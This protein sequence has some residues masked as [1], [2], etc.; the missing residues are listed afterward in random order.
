MFE[1]ALLET[2]RN[3]LVESPISKLVTEDNI[4]IT[5]KDEPP[6]TVGQHFI[7]IMPSQRENVSETG[8]TNSSKNYVVDRIGIDVVCGARTRLAPTDRLG[9]YMTKEHLNLSVLK[10]LV[11]TYVS[12]LNSSMNMGIRD[13]TLYLLKEYSEDIQLIL[14]EDIS[15]GNGFEYLSC[16]SQPNEKSPDYFSAKDGSESMSER[17]AGHTYIV[18]FLSP[19]RIYGVQC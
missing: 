3:K 17:P 2:L 8:D 4:F 13:K 14:K 19:S 1:R 12:K 10:D 7:L 18:R 6:P 9:F 15:I 11:I 5:A 16:D